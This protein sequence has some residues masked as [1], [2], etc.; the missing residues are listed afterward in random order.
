[1]KKRNRVIKKIFSSLLQ[2][3]I[4]LIG[5]TFISF[6]ILHLSPGNPAEIWLTGGD[7]NVGQISQEA[8]KA[9]EEKMGLDK[10]FLIQYGM[11]LKKICH[12][13]LGESFTTGQPVVSELQRRVM[14]TIMIAFVSLFLTMLISV[15]LGIGC[16]VYKDRW[17]DNMIRSVSF[18]GISL[19]T[20]FTS[21]VLLWLFC[22]KLSIF[23]VIA[24]TDV[25][26]MVLPVAVFVFQCSSRLTRQVRAVIL[27][28][29]NQ[30]Y[31]KGAVAR[32]VKKSRILFSHVLKNAMIPVLT[33]VSIYL[34]ILLGGAAVVET[35]FSWDGLG[36]LAVESVARLDYF[37]IQGFVL[38]VAVIFLA[39]NFL[40]DVICSMID[41]R[42]KQG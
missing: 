32:G 39:L 31:V 2:S 13:D 22:L 11:W 4:V 35:I 28:Q 42:I 36:K 5:I 7:G 6:L 41:P 12:G 25:K 29:L 37:V 27:E 1:M 33:W 10:P 19:P 34:G 3:L 16:A 21:L 18:L 14:P 9:Q 38:W 23:P 30:E 26:G 8:V 40:V 24:D 15:P 17:L 20:F